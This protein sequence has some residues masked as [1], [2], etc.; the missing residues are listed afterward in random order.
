[1]PLGT[2]SRF[3]HG[4]SGD[5]QLLALVTL[6]GLFV[7]II[8]AVLAGS[9]LAM[10]LLSGCATTYENNPRSMSNMTAAEIE[11]ALSEGMPK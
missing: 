5:R 1:M 4:V 3:L 6:K 2:M 7:L 8:P 10:L 11:R 9:F